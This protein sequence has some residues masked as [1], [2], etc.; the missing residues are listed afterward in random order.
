MAQSSHE[1]VNM[2][3]GVSHTGI[4]PLSLGLVIANFANI[5]TRGSLV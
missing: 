4:L 2:P 1:V 5:Y 3:Q